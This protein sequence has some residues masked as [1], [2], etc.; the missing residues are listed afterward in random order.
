MKMK[1]RPEGRLLRLP[2]NIFD[3]LKTP[4]FLQYCVFAKNVA[5]LLATID[6][7]WLQ[8]LFI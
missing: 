8:R 3:S 6:F 7:Q 2:K 1:S 5:A 4:S